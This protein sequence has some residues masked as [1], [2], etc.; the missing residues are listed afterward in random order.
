MNETHLHNKIDYG[1]DLLLRQII[2][3]LHKH[4]YDTVSRLIVYDENTIMEFKCNSKIKRIS[5]ILNA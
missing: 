2:I 3:L 4:I 5:M 1:T